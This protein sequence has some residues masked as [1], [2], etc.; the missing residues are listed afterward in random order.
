[1]NPQT[2]DTSAPIS[3]TPQYAAPTPTV[4]APR[5]RV[6]AIVTLVIGSVL[7]V[8]GP[9]LGLLI[10]SFSAISPALDIAAE[11]VRLE[12]SATVTVKSG[13]STLLLAPEGSDG[14]VSAAD[15][16]ASSGGASLPVGRTSSSTLNLLVNG[17][18]Y[19]SFAQVAPDAGGEVVLQCDSKVDVIA[20][21]PLSVGS[22]LGPIGAW[23][24]VGFA[25]SAVGIV[26]VITGIVRLVRARPNR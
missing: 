11:T 7:V 14:T 13:G 17:K 9:V 15:C 1:M 25:V 26:L 24:A 22:V 10:G 2:S 6:G 23:T 12:P 21:P 20:A 8:L 18:N 3:P 5:S 19:V 4:P 16:T